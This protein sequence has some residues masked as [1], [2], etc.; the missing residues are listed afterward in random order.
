MNDR[1]LL[2]LAAKSVGYETLWLPD[3]K[4]HVVNEFKREGRFWNPLENDGDAFRLAVTLKFM[5]Y[6]LEGCTEV[7]WSGMYRDGGT[8]TKQYY[9]SDITRASATRRAIVRAAAEIGKQNDP[10]R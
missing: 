3:G 1:E 2:E 6:I 5:V 8:E 9:D 10:T 7:I 4:L